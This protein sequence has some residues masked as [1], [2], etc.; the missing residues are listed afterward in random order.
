MNPFRFLTITACFIFCHEGLRAQHDTVPTIFPANHQDVVEG[1]LRREAAL[2]FA[3]L[4]LPANPGDWTAYRAALKEKIIEKAGVLINHNLALEM[5]KLGTVRMEGYTIFNIIFQTRPGVFATAN[6][7]VPD[8]DGPFPAVINMHAHAGRFD[9]EDQGVAHSLAVNGYVCLSIDPW[10]AGERTTIH[11]KKEYHGAGLGASFMNVGETLMGVEISDNMRGVDLLTSLPYVDPARIGATGA[12]GGGNQTMWLAAIDERVKAAVPVVSV[13]TFES[14]VMRDNCIC[15]TLVDGLNFT[16]EAGVLALIAPRA[17]KICNHLQ[18]RAPAFFPSEMLRSFKNAKPVFEM[19]GAGK[20]I[21]YQLFDRPHGY[22]PEDREAMLGFFDLHLKGVGTGKPKKEKPFR[23][24][25]DGELMV[26]QEGNRD[27]RVL[28]TEQYCR[29]KGNELR[30]I[31]LHSGKLDAS[32]KRAELRG[33][34]RVD[35]MPTV[36]KVNRY[37]NEDNWRRLVLETSDGKLIPVLQWPADAHAARYVILCNTTGKQ[38]ISPAVIDEWREKGSGIVLLDLSGTGESV[39]TIAR[40][41]DGDGSFHTLA[42]AELWLGRTLLGEWA[43][44]LNA[45]VAFLLSEQPQSRI[46]IEGSKEAGL[47]ALFLCA[48]EADGEKQNALHAAV[49]NIILRQAPI[50]YLFDKREGVDFYSMA[51]H[52]PGFLRWG[53]MSLVAA[54]TGKA[55]TFIDPLSMSGRQITGAQLS[56]YKREFTEMR[57]RCATGGTT[58][59]K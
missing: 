59:F 36:A 41:Y 39:S 54:L 15:E 26:F 16:E 1:R 9:D 57:K 29:R 40:K 28:T 33:V 17:V 24:L 56:D 13:G 2:R 19:T 52:L 22:L 27:P 38:H 47:A 51:I 50:T 11:G 25:H 49:E 14:Y 44:E 34:L 7:F 12:S 55:V 23:I 42:R 43:K 31:M 4:R 45:V 6:L 8:G 18:D 10:G 53:D 21:D 3:S 58:V 37:G 20:N 48:L 5:A 32:E 46:T 35:K 30:K